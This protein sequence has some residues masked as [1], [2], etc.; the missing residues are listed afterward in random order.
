[1]FG[2]G[3]CDAKLVI[4]ASWFS[5]MK[6]PVCDSTFGIREVK[7][8]K[9]KTFTYEIVCPS[10]Q[11]VLVPDRNSMVLKY[12]GITLLFSG[13]IFVLEIVQVEALT[14]FGML[15]FLGLIGTVSIVVGFVK[16]GLRA[17]K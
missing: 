5:T 4:E 3:L 1:M 6:C 12:V 17:K 10:C 16:G 2:A 14:R 9:M 8:K 11:A 13:L 7:D 15:A